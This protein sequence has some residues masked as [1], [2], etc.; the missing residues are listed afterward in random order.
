MYAFSSE[1]V[2][3]IF[4]HVIGFDDEILEEMKDHS[5][6]YDGGSIEN[7]ASFL[8]FTP[9]ERDDFIEKFDI[10]LVETKKELQM[11]KKLIS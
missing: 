11:L 10:T 9:D 7:L 2:N 1:R 8:H 3:A 4:T 5:Y 6:R